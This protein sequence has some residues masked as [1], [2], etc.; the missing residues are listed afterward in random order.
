MVEKVDDWDGGC[1]W[2]VDSD[3]SGCGGVN[4]KCGCVWLYCEDFGFL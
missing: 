4:F 2:G 1:V 3:D